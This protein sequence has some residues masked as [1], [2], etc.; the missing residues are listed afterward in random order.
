VPRV[1]LM[2]PRQQPAEQPMS[3]LPPKADIAESDREVPFVPKADSCSAAKT[4]RAYGALTH[5]ILRFWG[6]AGRVCGFADPDRAFRIAF[7]RRRDH[8][9]L[10]PRRYF[11]K[12]ANRFCRSCSAATLLGLYFMW[13]SSLSETASGSVIFDR[14]IIAL[15]A[16]AWYL[17]KSYTDHAAIIPG[18]TR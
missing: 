13:A 3:A 18:K 16:A 9:I 12:L 7:L 2:K 5:Q 15:V 4:L 6:N 14:K 17:A 11:A 10:R 1:S 8:Q